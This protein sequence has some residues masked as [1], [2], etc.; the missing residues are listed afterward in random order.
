MASNIGRATLKYGGSTAIANINYLV[1]DIKGE[2][3]QLSRLTIKD[4]SPMPELVGQDSYTEL[5]WNDYN[6]TS[7]QDFSK[8]WREVY[9]ELITA[10]S[11]AMQL[12]VMFHLPLYK[13][14]SME[15]LL[16]VYK[17][18]MSAN[19][20]M[21]IDCVGYCDDFANVIEPSLK[22][23]DDVA[24]QVAKFIAFRKEENLSLTQ[25]LIVLQNTNR[26]GI[27]LGLDAESLVN[28]LT[29]FAISCSNYYDELFPNVLEYKD[30]VAFGI[31]TIQVDK[32]LLLDYLLSRTL[33]NAMD[34]A[35][36]NKN[37]VSASYAGEVTDNILKDKLHLLTEFFAIDREVPFSEVQKQFGAAA[38]DIYNGFK[39]S[40]ARTKSIP[41]KTAI[42]ATLLSKTDCELFTNSI[43][44]QDGIRVYDLFSE[45][46]DFFIENDYG[47]CLKV[48]DQT[49]SNPIK[50]LKK[51][52]SLV[53]DLEAQR[54]DL[55]AQLTTLGQQ[56][57]K[58]HSVDECYL[59]DGVFHFKG[60]NF[61]LMPDLE[62]EPLEDTFVP[63][64]GLC[65]PESRDLRKG[66]RPIQNQ[67]AQGSC[68][69]HALAA[70]FEYAIKLSSSNELDLSEAFLYY[71]AREMDTIGDVSTNTDTGSRVKPA[72]QSLMKYGLAQEEFCRYNDED[73]TTKPSDEAYADA[74]NRKLIKAMN[75]NRSTEAIKAAL[76]E[77]YPVA[78][79]LALCKSF[80]SAYQDG[81]VPMPSQEEIEERFAPPSPSD[82]EPNEKHSSHAM[83]VVGYSDKLRRFIIRNSW[84][85]DWGDQGYCYV[86]YDY[87]DHPDLCQNATIFTEIASLSTLKMENIPTL[88]VDDQDLNIRYYITQAALVNI[89]NDLE[90]SRKRRNELFFI[91]SNLITQL[92]SQPNTRDN[93]LRAADDAL[94]KEIGEKR[95]RCREIED[96]LE[97]LA[98]K[99]RRYNI[100]TI[101][102]T[103][104]VVVVTF[105][106]LWGANKGVK[107]INEDNHISYFHS[108]WVFIPYFIYMIFATGKQWR[109]YREKKHELENELER[110]EA[111]I[112][113]REKIKRELKY[114]TF[115]T[116]HLMQEMN[117]VRNLLENRYLNHLHLLNNLRAWYQEIDLTSMS[118]MS[119]DG[120][121]VISLLEQSLL[122]KF[123]DDELKNNSKFEIDLCEAIQSDEL[124]KKE[125]LEE[126]RR[127]LVDTATIN[128][129]Q[130]PKIANF[131]MSKH[132]VDHAFG[133]LAPVD[134]KLANECARQADLFIHF[135]SSASPE[136]QVLSKLIAPDISD[137]GNGLKSMFQS[138]PGLLSSNDNNRVTYV[139]VAP[140]QTTDCEIL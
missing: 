76:S 18:V 12:Y 128:L 11:D 34:M 60:Q 114:K 137:Y 4:V 55:E 51:L 9:N 82:N 39:D 47:C 29:H 8:R 132:I 85:D 102:L 53:V 91:C 42:L 66:F 72:V 2:Q 103:V 22:E 120:I 36:V 33:L 84:G 80:G 97:E 58:S 15:N 23:K 78:I 62:Q 67:G 87:I 45:G 92:S 5:A 43:Y 105:L 50:E 38:D 122:D 101:L 86:P 41:E 133:W 44:N 93:Y 123:F 68:L 19:L 113:S 108:L 94:A 90:T 106:L 70:I 26:L 100:K 30:I 65:I 24:Q 32:Y 79:S 117:R 88:S 130:Y 17:G 73:F 3:L 140:L 136:I 37:N 104:A 129:Y 111:K 110:L 115:A 75:V 63:T 112:K 48:A 116:Y 131:N 74:A 10:E 59:E 56:I 13:A 134:K 96:Q 52:D 109:G 40:L 6:T 7:L 54:R 127:S 119:N 77:G 61:R 57:D 71:N 25:H 135:S 28:V 89:E 125:T 27:T 69:A 124:V 21:Q 31:S 121:P 95:E 99:Q 107:L 98:K 139:T 46:I 16:K 138:T 83:V 20:P 35:S 126:L 49:P 14:S 118:D 64:E 1:A 81:Y